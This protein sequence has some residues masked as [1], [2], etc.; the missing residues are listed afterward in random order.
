MRRRKRMTA[1]R[2]LE[3]WRALQTQRL[4]RHALGLATIAGT[5]VDRHGGCVEE[6]GG[7]IQRMPPPAGLFIWEAASG[8]E[9]LH[10]DSWNCT[11]FYQRGAWEQ[12]LLTLVEQEETAMYN[13]THLLEEPRPA[14][15]TP[16]R[17]P[18]CQAPLAPWQ[19]HYCG[20]CRRRR[21]DAL[22]VAGHL[23]HVRL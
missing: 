23:A 14:P 21:V 22:R 9:L 17:C 16:R 13:H 6:A 11:L 19:A 10:V 18:D 20:R 5:L 12:R 8:R 7:V 2:R 1:E 3:R 15:R 4:T